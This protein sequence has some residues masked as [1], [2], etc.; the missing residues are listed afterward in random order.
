MSHRQ[1][2]SLDRFVSARAPLLAGFVD[3]ARRLLGMSIVAGTYGVVGMGILIAGLATGNSPEALGGALLL[4][5][6]GVMAGARALVKRR[7]KLEP[8]P[9]VRLTPEAKTL[10]RMLITHLTGWPLGRLR[11]RRSLRRAM[12]RGLLPALHD[13]RCEDVLTPEA[14]ELLN[15]AAQEYNR[16]YGALAFDDQARNPTLDRLAPTISAAADETMG[17]ILHAAA[18]LDRF[19]ESG[20]R[21][22]GHA[23][24]QVE[25]LRELA[26]QVERL[27]TSEE[28]PAAL[29]E[30]RSRLQEVL[31]EIRAAQLAQEELRLGPAPAHERARG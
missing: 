8:L 10:L 22:Q 9:H 1:I 19:P 2:S 14:F 18:L 6:S 4:I 3:E 25:E 16:I 24:Q 13:R 30:G 11:R 28:P 12:R 23:S 20:S 15:S 21:V 5:P 27:Q 17:E 29:E 7:L 31:E 26:G